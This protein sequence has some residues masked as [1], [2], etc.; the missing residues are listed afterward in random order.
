MPWEPLQWV[1]KRAWSRRA[2]EGRA[3]TGS[4][5]KALGEPNHDWTLNP[6]PFSQQ[7]SVTLTLPTAEKN[8]GSGSEVICPLTKLEPRSPVPWASP[9]LGAGTSQR[10][11]QRRVGISH[12]LGNP[13]PKSTNLWSELDS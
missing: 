13:Q 7:E 4:T 8:K 5:G 3:G 10:P 6:N 9:R 12:A 1:E 11:L 2:L